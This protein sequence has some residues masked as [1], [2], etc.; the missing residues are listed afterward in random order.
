MVLTL[1]VERS[2]QPQARLSLQEKSP[3]TEPEKGEESPPPPSPAPDLSPLL[4]NLSLCLLSGCRRTST[5]A[6]TRRKL[7]V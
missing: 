2:S 7:H 1:R 4:E 5:L 6:P 3:P